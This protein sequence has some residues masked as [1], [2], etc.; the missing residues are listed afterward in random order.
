MYLVLDKQNNGYEFNTM[1]EAIK[2]IRYDLKYIKIQTIEN[3]KRI[4]WYRKLPCMTWSDKKEKL[5]EE[6]SL[7]YA[8]EKK[9]KIFWIARECSNTKTNDIILQYHIQMSTNYETLLDE[10]FQVTLL[11]VMDDDKFYEKYI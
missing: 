5:L 2:A 4:I 11:E 6:F 7:E 8:K 9:N 3:N 1:Q 10:L